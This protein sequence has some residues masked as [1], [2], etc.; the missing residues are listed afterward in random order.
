MTGDLLD[1]GRHPTLTVAQAAE[2]LGVSRATAYELVRLGRV[3]VV[4][5]SPRCFR[6]PTAT[7]AAMLGRENA[8][9]P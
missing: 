6:V 1:A 9:G 5:L 7:L 3:P 2:V 4:R 8:G